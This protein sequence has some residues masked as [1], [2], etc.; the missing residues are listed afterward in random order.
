MEKKPLILIV[1]D[2]GIEAPGIRHLW[3]AL[4]D[5][6]N[7][8]IVAP[9]HQQ[10]G[11]GVSITLHKPLQIDQIKWEKGTP[12]WRVSG[13]P[14]DCVKMALSKILPRTP[15][16][17][18]SG[19]NLGSN[20]GR[21]IFHSGTVGGVI[22]GVL[23]GIPGIA[24]SC[25][26]FDKPNFHLAEKYIARIALHALEHPLDPGT[27]LNV[28]FPT[29]RGDIIGFKFTRQGRGFWIDSPDERLRPDGSTYFWLGGA[30]NHQTEEETDVHYLEQGYMTAVPISIL[31]LTHYD[32][33]QKRKQIFEDLYTKYETVTS[34][35]V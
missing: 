34:S 24:F 21:S 32:M 26:D 20:S 17:I 28:T 5:I 11:C 35:D 31:D 12:A 3:S 10:S 18:V 13:T 33:L 27:F 15:D 30:W 23:R 1:N 19:I 16:L 2:D 9:W 4:V 6:A 29:Q 7:V 22:E 14:A 8:Y 25:E